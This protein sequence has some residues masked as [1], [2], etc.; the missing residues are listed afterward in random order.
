[1]SSPKAQHFSSHGAERATAR[2]EAI[3]TYSSMVV[4]HARA[5]ERQQ[6]CLNALILVHLVGHWVRLAATC[7]INYNSYQ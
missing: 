2:W 3:T 7:F 1:M 5:A 4:R 6:A